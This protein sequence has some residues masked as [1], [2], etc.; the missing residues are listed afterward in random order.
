M[1]FFLTNQLVGGSIRATIPP[2]PLN[3]AHQ[4]GYLFL[5]FNGGIAGVS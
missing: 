3:D 5:A 1:I 2:T 4:G